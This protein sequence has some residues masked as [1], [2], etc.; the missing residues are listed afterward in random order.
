MCLSEWEIPDQPNKKFETPD[1]VFLD[2]KIFRVAMDY[3]DDTQETNLSLKPNKLTQPAS[4]PVQQNNKP[5]LQPSPQPTGQNNQPAQ[6][7]INTMSG[8]PI[9]RERFLVSKLL[10]HLKC[11]EDESYLTQ[12]ESLNNIAYR[13]KADDG[14]TYEVIPTFLTGIDVVLNFFPKSKSGRTYKRSVARQMF[15]HPERWIKINCKD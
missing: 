15:E 10:I 13:F 6:N 11:L 2:P 9:E 7:T 8:F 5:V 1:L 3:I 12:N 4:K 14:S